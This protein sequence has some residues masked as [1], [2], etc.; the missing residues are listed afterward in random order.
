MKFRLEKY[1][2][3]SSRYNCPSCGFPRKFTR[4]VD[5]STGLHLADNVGRCDRESSCGYH[6]KPK[7]FFV[8]QPKASAR[9]ANPSFRRRCT[10]SG[11]KTD[12]P[13]VRRLH[14][15]GDSIT[16]E[17]V[18]ESLDAERYSHNHLLKFLLDTFRGEEVNVIDAFKEYLVGT[19]SNGET[20]FWQIDEKGRVPTGKVMVY[21]PKTG[22]RRKDRNPNWVHA[23]LKRTGQVPE[24]YV[25]RQCFFGQ[26]L[27]SKDS[28]APVAIVES[29]KTA[30][31]ANILKAE[32]PE[33]VWLATGGKSGLTVPKLE[34]IGMDRRILLYPDADAF[35]SWNGIA[36]SAR[37]RG[38]DVQVSRLI[39]DLAAGQEPI[40]RGLD[41]ADCLLEIQK[42]NWIIE[43]ESAKEQAEERIAIMTIDG[44][45][46]EEDAHSYV[47][48][49][50]F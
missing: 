11:G 6:F 14:P 39:Q 30:I 42:R 25:L 15:E 21:E 10:T 49:Q 35:E 34:K 17:L 20:I 3:P 48:R 45:L 16:T 18:L 37:K 27:L 23:M 13:S 50:N 26:H 19:G 33:I 4:Y 44:H 24:T 1:N 29:E 9:L 32:F 12:T 36:A 31:V 2:G 46:S 7:D 47:R 38:M 43:H 22:K 8:D 40:T 5:L 41:I 28:Q